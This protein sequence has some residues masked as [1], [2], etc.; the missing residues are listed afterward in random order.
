VRWNAHRVCSVVARTK[1]V[2]WSSYRVSRVQ[3][4]CPWFARSADRRSWS[5]RVSER[6][7]VWSC[8]FTC[9]RSVLVTQGKTSKSP[10]A[11]TSGHLS[12]SLC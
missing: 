2:A 12:D 7:V 10:Q 8:D 9:R 3:F 5:V 4:W 11:N 6:E 1:T